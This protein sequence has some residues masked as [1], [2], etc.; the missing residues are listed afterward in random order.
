MAAILVGNR[1]AV[2]GDE[3][4]ADSDLR[5]GAYVA[6]SSEVGPVLSVDSDAVGVVRTGVSDPATFLA[7]GNPSPFGVEIVGVT[8][9][10]SRS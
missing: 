2:V 6:G 3:G 7:D 10:F 9:N 5:S 8:G 4:F 1:D